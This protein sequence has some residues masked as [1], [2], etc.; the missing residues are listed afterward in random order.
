MPHRKKMTLTTKVLW[1][2]A[3]GALLGLVINYSSMGSKG[4]FLDTYIINGLFALIGTLFVKALKMLVVP[5]V[6]FSL[7]S[8][9]IGIGDIRSLGKIG[10]KS[11]V[12]YIFTT[13][14]AITTAIVVAVLVDPAASVPAPNTAGFA[15]KEAPP[16]TQVITDIIPDNIIESFASGNML[17]VIFF[18]ILLGISILM[19]GPKAS[20]L[21]QS[22]ETMNEVMMHMVTI[23]MSVAP[24]AVFALMARAISELGF[25][26]ILA[27]A[28]YMLILVAVLALHLLGNLMLLLKLLTGISPRLFLS[29]IRD[30]QLFA[31]STSS[32]N[33]TIPVTLRSLTARLG[34]DNS[35]ASF[36]VPFGATINM[37]GTAIMQGV[38]TIFIANIYGVE[39]GITQYLTVILM[40][41]LASIGTAGVPGVG[42]IMLSMVFAQV[43]LPVEGIAL[44]LAVDRI[45]DMAR[46]VVN[47]TGDAVTTLI[48]A[49][50]EGKLDMK[51]LHDPHA[52]IIDTAGT[53]VDAENGRILAAEIRQTKQK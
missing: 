1:A 49:K 45:L 14:L 15:V 26:M 51:V 18:T 37:D 5:L 8:G 25:D 41:I 31:F 42:L 6:L 53:S 2:M 23:I 39:L 30:V 3:L 43:G 33:A 36:T 44:I 46:T 35:V 50:S 52:G 20:R 34:V 11:F 48:V 4:T 22:I 47:V 29:K 13:A 19:L 40:A 32:S 27:L 17:Q 7:L 12:L 38:A 9:V 16:L 24:Y 21:A 10:V 28:N